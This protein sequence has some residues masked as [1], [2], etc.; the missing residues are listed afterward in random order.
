MSKTL[1]SIIIIVLALSFALPASAQDAPSV[2]VS[3]LLI[4]DGPVSVEVSPMLARASGEVEVWVQ[5]VD[6]PLA[7]AH[8]RDAK[9]RG[10]NLSREQQSEYLRGLS[11]K[12]DALMGQIRSL[13]GT[14]LARVS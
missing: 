9:Q 10:G 1:R 13:G 7:V 3:Q 4:P 14:E 11:Q 12:Q 2:D 8:G 5:L 6:E